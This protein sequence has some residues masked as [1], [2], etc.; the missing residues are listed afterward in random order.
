MQ[1]LDPQTKKF[2]PFLNGI[3]ALQ[4]VLSPDHQLMIYTEYPTMH[5]WKSRPDGTDRVQLTSSPA[6]MEQWSPD[7]KSIAY[8]DWKKI[9]IISADGGVPQQIPPSNGDQVAPSWSPDGRSLYFNN[10]PYPGQPIKGIQ[11]LD[12]AAQQIS[13]MP[14]SVGYYVPSWSPDGKYLVAMAQNPLRMVLYTA[15][16]KQWKVLKQF[17][18]RWGYWIWANDSRSIYMAPTLSDVGVYQLTVPDGKWTKLSG[19]DGITLR[20]LAPDAFLSLTADNRP[21]FMSDTSVSQ[22]YSLHWK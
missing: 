4:F 9:F 21:V 22:I 16:T 17:D 13:F 1:A 11:I 10:F 5:L 14:G 6:Y 18:L 2:V 3:S 8:M 12:L 20:G 15:A 19:M 7:G